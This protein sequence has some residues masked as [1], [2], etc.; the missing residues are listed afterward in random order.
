MS[1]QNGTAASRAPQGPPYAPQTWALGGA[2][3]K[4]V[5]IPVQTIFM[6][7]F[8]VSA[9]VHMKIFQKNRA[10]GF[11]FLPNLFIFI[12][13]ISRILTSIL[14]IASVSLPR[15]IKLAIAAQIFVA[16]GVLIIFI[17][18]IIFA[19]RLVRSTHPSLGWHPG[20]SIAFKL[21][22]F[23]TLFTLVTVIGA[24]VESFYTLDAKKRAVD[25]SLQLYGAT[26][27]AIVAT[28]PLPMSLLTLLIPYSPL[29]RFGSGRLR[30][31]VI[32]LLVSTVFLSMGAWYRAGTSFQTPVPR[33]QPLPGSLSKAPFYIFNFFVELQTVLMYAILRIDLRFHVPNGARGAG[34]YSGSHKLED[35][36]LQDSRPTSLNEKKGGKSTPSPNMDLHIERAETP[37]PPPPPPKFTDRSRP[38]SQSQRVSVI[39][40]RLTQ[41]FTKTSAAP[42]HLAPPSLL[43]SRHQSFVRH[44]S[45]DSET[46]RIVRQLGGPWDGPR[47]SSPP[48]ASSRPRAS[49]P[50]RASSS[51]APSSNYSPTKSAYADDYAD[52]DDADY[53]AH[54]IMQEQSTWQHLGA[55]RVPPYLPDTVVHDDDW[56]PRI[57][58]EFRSPRRF[59]SLKKRNGL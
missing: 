9:A 51:K 18:N 10:R 38:G 58:W 47:A 39:S 57:D 53:D 37:P 52:D 11:K 44:P 4:Q 30:T 5:D 26:F 3:V 36:E 34:S 1:S 2:P 45:I 35:V 43:P 55:G 33:S 17:I 13:C 59:R 19:M 27:L 6:F 50:P 29:D 7:L 8:M 15:N 23:L 21:L 41:I 22:C 12:F 25:R 48:R 42:S 14:R 28:L 46:A 20:F 56:T 32:A 31:K 54:S 24:T 40:N 49:S 16:A